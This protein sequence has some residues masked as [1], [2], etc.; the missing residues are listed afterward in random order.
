MTSSPSLNNISSSSDSHNS[1]I[2]PSQSTSPEFPPRPIPDSH[3]VNLRAYACL[4]RDRIHWTQCLNLVDDQNARNQMLYLDHINQTIYNL[5]KELK[6]QKRVAQA[7]VNSPFSKPSTNEMCQYLHDEYH[8]QL[9]Q[10]QYHQNPY[11]VPQVISVS[12]VSTPPLP[13]TSSSLMLID[14][15]GS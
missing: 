11:P 12:P 14:L 6:Q 5:E 1:S 10:H 8:Q 13:S 3:T 15:L 2:S 9:D 7:N 4:T